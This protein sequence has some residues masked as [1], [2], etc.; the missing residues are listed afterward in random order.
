MLTQA[1]VVP[2]LLHHN[3]IGTASIVENDLLVADA[4]RRNRNFKVITEHGPSY[5]LKQGLGPGGIAT[6]AHEAVVYQFL[7]LRAEKDGLDR[8][9]PRYY[10][11]DPKEQILILQLLRDAQDFREYHARRGHFSTILARAM[12]KAL[13]AVHRLTRTDGKE[14]EDGYVFPV[15]PPRAL[16]IHRPEPRMFHNISSANVQH[17]K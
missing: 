16:S 13:A 17:I 3:L 6:V 4:S 7:Y 11:Y 12:G 8:Y 1:E 9:L 5:L 14:N 10:E 2:Y 15:Q